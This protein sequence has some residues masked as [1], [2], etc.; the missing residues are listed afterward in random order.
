VCVQCVGACAGVRVCMLAGLALSPC[1]SLTF[2]TR[3]CPL[4][5]VQTVLLSEGQKET[6][7]MPLCWSPS[8]VQS[9]LFLRQSQMT[10]ADCG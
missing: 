6:F 1:R 8:E 10:T 4:P 9:F 2:Q 5:D 3:T 7:D